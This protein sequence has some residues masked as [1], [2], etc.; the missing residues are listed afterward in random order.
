MFRRQF[1]NKANEEIKVV[2][3]Q[4]Q[5]EKII[6][7]ASEYCA[8]TVAE[9]NIKEICQVNTLAVKHKESFV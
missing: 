9:N 8:M 7:R 3:Y 2:D 6:K 4:L 5:Q 1:K